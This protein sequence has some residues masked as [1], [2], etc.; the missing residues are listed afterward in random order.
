MSNTWTKGQVRD[1]KSLGDNRTADGY[2]RTRHRAGR[3]RRLRVTNCDSE[4]LARERKPAR[5]ASIACFCHQPLLPWRPLSG[6]RDCSP[7]RCPRQAELRIT[8]S[9]SR[10][11]EH[12]RHGEVRSRPNRLNSN[13]TR[14]HSWNPVGGLLPTVAVP[15]STRVARS[16]PTSPRSSFVWGNLHVSWQQL[17]RTR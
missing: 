17:R 8:C 11:R 13:R 1:S 7:P 14:R 5:A 2:C 3:A 6:Q 10:G 12:R 9:P 4:Y 15:S 16:G